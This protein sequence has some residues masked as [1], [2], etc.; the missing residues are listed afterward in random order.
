MWLGTSKMPVNA[1]TVT[2]LLSTNGGLTFPIVLASAVPNTGS[3]TVMLPALTS[4]AARVKVQADG[5]VFFAISPG[6][7]T[8]SPPLNPILQ[9]LQCSKGSV[10]LAWTAIP[11]RSYCVQYKT[12]LGGTW[13]DLVSNITATNSPASI[14]DSLSTDQRYYRVLLVQ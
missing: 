3:C 10:R 14:T 7:F 4:S 12:V 8:I 11:G 6:D 1:A 9:P 5:N 13:I 2:L